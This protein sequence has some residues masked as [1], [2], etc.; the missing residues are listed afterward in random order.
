M[1]RQSSGNQYRGTVP[2]TLAAG[3]RTRM[4]DANGISRLID[5][6]DEDTFLENKQIELGRRAHRQ[7]GFS[8][9]MA[10]AASI[11]QQNLT[12]QQQARENQRRSD[13][14]LRKLGTR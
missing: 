13:R 7:H 8:A 2:R 5:K 14:E 9:T 4:K 1:A 11:A 12:R 6:D 3:L 10:N